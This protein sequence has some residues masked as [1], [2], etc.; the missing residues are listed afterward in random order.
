M[1]VNQNLILKLSFIKAGK[2][3]FFSLTKI[4]IV[5]HSFFYFLWTK[6]TPN[7][8]YI[9]SEQNIKLDL[10]LKLQSY[11]GCNI[12]LISNLNDLFIMFNVCFIQVGLVV[13]Y[14][15]NIFVIYV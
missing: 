9:Y 14:F 7:N 11:V 1:V 12:I 4:E 5:R 13:I 8:F 3:C 15:F 6:I 2:T 10:N